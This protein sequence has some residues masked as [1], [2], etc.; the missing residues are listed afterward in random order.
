[1]PEAVTAPPQTNV[2][3]LH[4]GARPADEVVAA[5]E[6]S[7][8]R[9]SSVGTHLV[10]AVTHLDVTTEECVQAGQVLGRILS[11]I[12][13]DHPDAAVKAPNTAWPNRSHDRWR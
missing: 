10:R 8:V 3:A 11:G 7:G 12:K 1:M 4:T 6:A 2:V 9:V 5:A 13:F